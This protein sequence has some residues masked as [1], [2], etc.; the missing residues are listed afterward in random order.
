MKYIA[1]SAKDGHQAQTYASHIEGVCHRALGYA[2]EVEPYAK[3][4]CGQFREIVRQSAV[5]HDLGKLD[6]ANQSVLNGENQNVCRLPINHVDAGS[7]LLRTQGDLYA[8]LSV[9]SHHRGLP[10]LV[11]E[12]LREDA[13]FRDEDSSVRAHTD[14]TLQ[15][16]IARHKEVIS[17][18]PLTQ[19]EPYEGDISV[20]LRMLLSC[21]T[22]ADHTDTAVSYGQIT[23]KDGFPKLRAEARLK[24]LDDYVATLKDDGE[25]SQLRRDMYAA[26]RDAN[27]PCNIAVCDSP[28]GSGKTTA[29]MAH[30]LKQAELRK[31]RHVFVV[32]SY[33]AIIQQAVDVYRKALVFPEENPEAV[34]AELHCRAEFQSTDTRYLTALWR[35]PIVVTTAVAFFETLAS[36]RPAT[37]RRLHEL[38]GSV[39]FIDESHNALPITLLPLAWK[40]MNALAEEWSCYW[41]LASGSLVR[42]WE[43]SVLRELPLPQ[44]TVCKLVDASLRER[45]MAYEKERVRF[46]WNPVPMGRNDFIQWTESFSGPRLIIVNTIQTAAVLANDIAHRYGEGHTEHLSTALIAEDRERTIQRI[47]KRLNDTNDTNWTLV[48]TSCVESGVD[49]SFRSGFRELSSLLS[50]LQ[51]SGR[52]N[53]HGIF[54]DSEMWSFTF[55]DDF[56]LKSNPE[57][58]TS[59]SVLKDYFSDGREITP[60]LSTQSLQ[61][62]LLR[63][64]GSIHRIKQIMEDES[65]GQFKTVDE[66]FVIFDNNTV[67]VL[68]DQSLVD[69]VKSGKCT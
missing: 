62:E 36:C 21:L 27:T 11:T 66:N 55:R 5:W 60:Q 52:V 7:A 59:R 61:D 65:N 64:F 45:L 2:D 24:R 68:V 46:L 14:R 16:L 57:L 25:R 29:I 63:N 40:W 31:A 58:D 41:S 53:R 20:F 13:F 69:M 6:A 33:T 28:V 18:S 34:V 22:D 23:G 12:G 67:P 38:P 37:L 50:L 48:A 42:F 56:L 26:C 15:E 51:S 19:C 47:K 8:A 32:L 1:H 3:R 43:L 44:P 17:D 35:A 39:I 10:D 54:T 9:Y 4:S 30:L 49:F